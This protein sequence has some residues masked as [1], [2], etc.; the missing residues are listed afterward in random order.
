MK[1]IALAAFALLFILVTGMGVYAGQNQSKP[2]VLFIVSDDLRPE[3]GCYGHPTIKSPNIDRL[4]ATGMRFNK[5]YVQQAVCEFNRDRH[6][7]HGVSMTDGRWRYTQ[8][9]DQKT[10]EVKSEELYDHKDTLLSKINQAA[11][12]KYQAELQWMR[13]LC[14]KGWKGVR[15]DMVLSP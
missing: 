2:N 4:A 9:R 1:R 8:W 5:A 13:A 10:G 14:A 12:P 3:L 11:N 7:V 6:G 15:E